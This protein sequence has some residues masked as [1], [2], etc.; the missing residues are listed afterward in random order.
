MSLVEKVEQWNREIAGSFDRAFSDLRRQLQERV[1]ESHQDLDRRIEAFAP[2]PPVLAHEDL[3]PAADRLRGEARAGAFDELRDAL[4]AL[5]RARSQSAVLAALIAGAGQVAARAALLLCR[6]GELSGWGSQG[7]GDAE[8]SLREL[9][10][11]PSAG[12]PWGRVDGGAVQ[13]SA[14]D[15]AVLCGRI[16]SPVPAFGVLIPLVLRDRTVAVLYAD[17]LAERTAAAPDQADTLSLAALQS[18]VY[19][20]ALAIESLP[21]RQREATATLQP[22]GAASEAAAA[23]A[24]AAPA[25]APDDQSAAAPAVAATPA[26][27][28][29]PAIDAA[30]AAQAVTLQAPA[31]PAALEEPATAEEPAAAEEQGAAAAAAD[32][33]AGAAGSAA[34]AAPASFETPAAPDALPIPATSAAAAATAESA[35]SAAPREAT[36][37]ET[38]ELSASPAAPAAPA[39]PETSPAA[40]AAPASGAPFAVTPAAL[41]DAPRAPAAKETAEI[42]THRPLWPVAPLSPAASETASIPRGDSPDL[43]LAAS[44]ASAAAMPETSPAAGTD[45][46]AAGTASIPAAPTES[47][48]HETVLLPHAALRDAA[49]SPWEKRGAAQR[50]E[51]PR[52]GAQGLTGLPELPDS[53]AAS[54]APEI[55]EASPPATDTQATAA[56]PQ[57]AV[58]SLGTSGLGTLRAVP[59]VPPLAT[60]GAGS[61]AATV[62]GSPLPPPALAPVPPASPF[63]EPLRTGPLGSGTPEVRPPIGV[64]GPGWAFATTRI[65]ASSSEEALHEEARRLAR[66]LVSEIKLYNEEQV[67]AGRRNRDIYERLREDIDRSRQMYEERVEPRLVKSTDYFYQELVRILAAGDSKALGI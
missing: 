58:G 12:S 52:A 46:A 4:A 28:A 42:P 16:E 9:V 41:Y 33:A 37:A 6:G 35:G 39:P 34:A 48:E 18:L 40:T 23:A 27:P 51:A 11:T 25:P 36:S 57:G 50:A 19:V 2:P 30:G 64:Q 15:C 61:A 44:G 3:V 22:A 54:G 60:A 8:Q 59:S 13:L 7:F 20:A 24:A 1:R 38:A 43:E 26:T 10:M 65:Q 32:T 67:E 21:F 17:Q 14:A 63:F 31:A 55:R 49:G 62:P 29:T 66:L 5:D 47:G 56:S 45:A 53:S